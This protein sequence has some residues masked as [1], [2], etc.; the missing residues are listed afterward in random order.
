MQMLLLL[1]FH[2]NRCALASKRGTIRFPH[3]GISSMSKLF[4]SE[5]HD[6]MQ[7]LFDETI[8][9]IQLAKVS[10]DLDDLSATFA[11]ALLKLGLAT[12]FVEQKYPGFAKEVEVKRQRVIAALTQEQQKSEPRH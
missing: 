10:P 2:C 6:A 7:Q 11:V 1:S 9:A 12:G 5:L 4:E 3:C 8:E